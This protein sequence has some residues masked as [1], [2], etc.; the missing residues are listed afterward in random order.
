M[1]N[2]SVLCAI[3][4][5]LCQVEEKCFKY[6]WKQIITFSNKD[7]LKNQ[8]HVYIDRH[9]PPQ[10]GWTLSAL[11]IKLMNHRGISVAPHYH[12]LFFKLFSYLPREKPPLKSNSN[13]SLTAIYPVCVTCLPHT[14]KWNQIPEAA[15]GGLPFPL[16]LRLQW[17]TTTWPHIKPGFL[18]LFNYHLPEEKLN[19]EE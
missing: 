1:E 2:N 9:P 18:S 12:L 16:T 4:V 8:A 10:Q 3:F 5:L 19:T 14:N 15:C 6:E 11:P 7:R 13:M 17:G